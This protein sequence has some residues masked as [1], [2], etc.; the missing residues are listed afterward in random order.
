M[1]GHTLRGRRFMQRNEM[2]GRS[3]EAGR[4]R[5]VIPNRRDV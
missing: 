1:I 5:A 3:A 2:K 4:Y